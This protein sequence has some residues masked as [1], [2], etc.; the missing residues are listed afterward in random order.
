MDSFESSFPL[1]A[2]IG[3]KNDRKIRNDKTLKHFLAETITS[4]L[5]DKLE[6]H[7]T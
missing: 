6:S 1:F 2:A 7:R 4:I 5:F 3:E